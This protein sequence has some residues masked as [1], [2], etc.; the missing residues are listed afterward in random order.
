VF[1]SAQVR[2]LRNGLGEDLPF[3]TIAKRK[4]ELQEYETQVYILKNRVDDRCNLI[5][6]GECAISIR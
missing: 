6:E 2:E 5:S 3:R 1:R 4:D